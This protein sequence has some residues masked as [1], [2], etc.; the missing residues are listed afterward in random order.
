MLECITG[1]FKM[2][3]SIF[4]FVNKKTELNNTPE[5]IEAAKRQKAQN[6]KDKA[7]EA[8]SSGNDDE[9][10]NHLS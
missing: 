3:G 8:I 10:R 1:F 4:G 5:M 9:I 6:E 2:V 7:N